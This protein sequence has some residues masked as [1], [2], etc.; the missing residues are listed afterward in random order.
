MPVP[1]QPHGGAGGYAGGGNNGSLG[2]MN[3]GQN[4][5]HQMASSSSQQVLTS[6]QQSQNNKLPHEASQLRG[7]QLQWGRLMAKGVELRV[8]LLK[9]WTEDVTPQIPWVRPQRP[10]DYLQWKL[11]IVTATTTQVAYSAFPVELHS[12]DNPVYVVTSKEERGFDLVKVLDCK[13][14][15]QHEISELA[16]MIDQWQDCPPWSLVIRMANPDEISA[17]QNEHQRA[18]KWLFEQMQRAVDSRKIFITAVEFRFDGRDLAMIYDATDGLGPD[19]NELHNAEDKLTELLGVQVRM[20]RSQDEPPPSAAAAAAS[21]PRHQ[22]PTFLPSFRDPSTGNMITFEYSQV[23]G[24]RYWVNDCERPPL[25][26]ISLMVRGNGVS[27]CFLEQDRGITLPRNNHTKIIME[28]TRYAN[29][30]KVPHNLP[31][32]GQQSALQVISGKV[33]APQSPVQGGLQQVFHPHQHQQQQQPQQQQPQQQ[34]QQSV[35]NVNA[36]THPHH[37]HHHQQQHVVHQMSGHQIIQQ[38]PPTQPPKQVIMQ[39]APNPAALPFIPSNQQQAQQPSRRLSVTNPGGPQLSSV[40]STGGGGVR[41]TSSPVIASVPSS[42]GPASIA[43]APSFDLHG[44]V[45]SAQGI[46]PVSPK[47]PTPPPGQPF[48]ASIQSSQTGPPSESSQPPTPTQIASPTHPGM[49]PGAPG[50]D[51]IATPCHYFQTGGC[52]RGDRCRYRH[53][54][55]SEQPTNVHIP[56]KMREK[57]RRAIS[58]TGEDP[59]MKKVDDEIIPIVDEKIQLDLGSHAGQIE[60]MIMNARES[61][62]SY[63]QAIDGFKAIEDEARTTIIHSEMSEFGRLE[64]SLTGQMST[65]KSMIAKFQWVRLQLETEESGERF[66]TSEEE[67][68]AFNEIDAEVKKITSWYETQRRN[69]IQ[70]KQSKTHFTAS[71]SRPPPPLIPSSMVQGFHES[72]S[73]S[74]SW[75]GAPG[76]GFSK[77][78]KTNQPGLLFHSNDLGI[79]DSEKGGKADAWGDH[80]TGSREQSHNNSNNNSSNSNSTGHNNH[81]GSRH[82]NDRDR[83]S[84]V[85]PKRSSNTSSNSNKVC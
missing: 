3:M 43:S 71:V 28:L 56:E 30:A 34:Q 25:Q 39:S 19:V 64:T 20:R 82:N 31:D 79:M 74:Q 44:S 27:L 84:R 18:E 40:D 29:L 67:S 80:H 17:Y 22:K 24:L 33:S 23:N 9:K 2:G 73:Q 78:E 36:P 41:M 6:P 68:T 57:V 12:I 38:P 47:R 76:S 69:F 59:K 81:T 1:P 83:P 15:P 51:K 11:T 60:W 10:V 37:H 54:Y 46:E 66:G 14:T 42:A 55:P 62:D 7:T 65:L 16:R 75:Q 21:M 35:Q 85:L 63:L 13:A 49:T 48:L 5:G 72:Q 61:L 8:D 32:V 77:E 4:P 52:S 50:A 70:Q 53:V 58:F 45:G 26:S